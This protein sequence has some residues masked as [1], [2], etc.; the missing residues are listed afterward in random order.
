MLKALAAAF[1]L[2]VLVA[3]IPI[4]EWPLLAQETP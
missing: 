3:R 2:S 4:E 1:L